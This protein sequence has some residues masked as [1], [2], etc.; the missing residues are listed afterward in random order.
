MSELPRS[1][2]LVKVGDLID[3]N[4]KSEAP[5]V[6]EAGFVPLKSMGVR[7]RDRHA[8]EKRPWGEVKKG[9]TH[10]G[11]G[12]VLLARITPSFENG[13]AGIARDLPNGIGAG[14]TE[15]FVCRPRE[16]VVLPE[17]LLAHFKT[18]PFLE[19][20][21]RVMSGAVGQQRVPKRY[22]LDS[23]VALAPLNEQQR[24]A[25]KL[26][27]LLGRV[28]ACRE[29]LDR[30]PLIIKRFRQAVLAA[31]T[32]GELTADWRDGPPCWD[33]VRVGAL[34]LE[35]PRNGFSPTSVDYPTAV[36]SL[37]LTA[38]T[39]GRFRPEHF[40]YIDAKIPANSHLW[41][42]PGDVLVQRAN[43]L[44][45]VGVS[46]VY[47]GPRGEFIYPDL[48][49]KCRANDRIRP[50]YLHLLLLSEPVRRYFRENATGT[51]GSMPKIN[52]R[53]VMGAPACIPMTEEQDEIIRRV[54]ALF[55]YADRLEARYQVARA[56]VDGLTPAVLAKAFRGELVPQDPNDEPASVLLERIRASRA[57]APA[58]PQRSGPG[59]RRTKAKEPHQD[60]RSAGAS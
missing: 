49:M 54:E 7:F 55:A 46:A 25:D 40:K 6:A 13:K 31:A 3:L 21:E 48:M 44:E 38:T 4:P 41:L 56:R 29:R 52:Q 39:S 8:V 27:A 34:L 47:D 14:S 58:G 18:R 1:W 42:E 15:Y 45:Y 43:T 2:V 59:V 26:D 33:E 53:T 10:F 37:T 22:L 35:K 60:P 17:Y 50:R 12:D 28:D 11:N 5:D 16:G 24:I 20:G 32:C 36:K 9:Y 19:A 30:V 23:P 57:A 51:A